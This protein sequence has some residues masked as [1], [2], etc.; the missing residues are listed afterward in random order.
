MSLNDN[1]PL[2]GP[3]GNPDV[4]AGEQVSDTFS[5]LK[6]SDTVGPG[7]PAEETDSEETVRDWPPLHAD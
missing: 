5:E 4:S 2:R 3:E 6:G 1:T 7:E